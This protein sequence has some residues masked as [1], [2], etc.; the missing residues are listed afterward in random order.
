MSFDADG[1]LYGQQLIRARARFRTEAAGLQDLT[2]RVV[3]LGGGGWGVGRAVG[4][5]SCL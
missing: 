3:E 1:F 4:R 2:P 5:G